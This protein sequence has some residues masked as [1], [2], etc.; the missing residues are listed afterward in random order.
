[1]P[2]VKKMVNNTKNAPKTKFI[3]IISIFTALYAV[4]RI[5][6]TVPMVGGSGAAFSLSDII[7]PIYGL[8][9]GPY[10]GGL[11]VILGS[12]LAMFGKT[13]VFLGLDFLPA[14]VAAVSVGLLM[15]RKWIPIIG[16]NIAL[17][18]AFLLHPNTSIF[19]NIPLGDTTIPLPFAWVHIVALLL[20]ISPLGRK[21][22]EWV[23][24]ISAAKVAIGVAILFF[25]GTMMQHLMGNLLFETIFPAIGY[26]PVTA[27][28]TQPTIWSGIFFLYPLERAALVFFGTIV[29]TPLI[30]IL[31]KNFF[32]SED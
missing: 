9:L 4:L 15:K 6:P 13:P 12:F 29:G 26:I 8:I 7:A 19:V 14:T 25:I 28:T 17:L 1:M 10:I 31:K 30:R 32:L 18:V 11:S 22:V 3:A 5:I 23:K 20:L 16:L 21:A 24:A 2:K 27:F